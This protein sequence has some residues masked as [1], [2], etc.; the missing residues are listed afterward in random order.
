M[1]QDLKTEVQN[2]INQTNVLKTLNL[3]VEL[4]DRVPVNSFKELTIYCIG[5]NLNNHNGD[6]FQSIYSEITNINP[7]LLKLSLGIYVQFVFKNCVVDFMG[8]YVEF[9]DS[10]FFHFENSTINIYIEYKNL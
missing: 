10:V 7:S 5:E 8:K 6:K 9:L 2:I 3:E 4:N 1:K